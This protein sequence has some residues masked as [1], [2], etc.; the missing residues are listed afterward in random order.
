MSHDGK[1]FLSIDEIEWDMSEGPYDTKEEA[2]AVAP[3]LAAEHETPTVWVGQAKLATPERLFDKY[4]AES[5]ILDYI[6][7]SGYDEY[8]CEDGFFPDD[9]KK[10]EELSEKLAKAVQEILRGNMCEWYSFDPDLVDLPIVETS[11]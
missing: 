1:W 5:A 6:D 10:R 8:A 7:E 11:D 9:R 4:R 2:L 3:E